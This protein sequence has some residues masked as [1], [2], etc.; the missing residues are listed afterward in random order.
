MKKRFVGLTLA[1]MLFAATTFAF[2]VDRVIIYYH[3]SSHFALLGIFYIPGY[4]CPDSES[5]SEGSTSNYREITTFSECG[6][7]GTSTTTCQEYVNGQWQTVT[8]Q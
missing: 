5:S 8:C 7:Q 2:P 1:C 6:Y 4:T 3:D